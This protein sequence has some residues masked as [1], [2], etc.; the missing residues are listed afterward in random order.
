MKG[1][2]NIAPYG[3]RMPEKLKEALTAR[4]EQNGRSLNSEIVMILQAAI[5]EDKKPR[6]VEHL[7]QQE[8]DRFKRALMETL[9]NM[10]EKDS[11]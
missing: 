7:A 6:S 5:D 3:V 10:N 8:A 1:M 11:E 4:A 9:K 2:R